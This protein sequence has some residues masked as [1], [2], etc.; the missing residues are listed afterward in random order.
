V[1]ASEEILK[2]DLLPKAKD[3]PQEII[4][5]VTSRNWIRQLV[6]NLLRLRLT[7]QGNFANSMSN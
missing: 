3:V 6:R 4:K 2:G 7:I 5:E 1:F